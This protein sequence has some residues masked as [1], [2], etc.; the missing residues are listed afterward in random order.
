MGWALRSSADQANSVLVDV[1]AMVNSLATAATRG[2]LVSMSS[3]SLHLFDESMNVVSGSFLRRRPVTPA[4]IPTPPVTTTSVRRMADDVTMA[5]GSRIAA[6]ARGGSEA[7]VSAGD[8]SAMAID[9]SHLTLPSSVSRVGPLAPI[10]AAATASMLSLPMFNDKHVT[11][12]PEC[13]SDSSI[14][15]RF[16]LANDCFNRAVRD[17]DALAASA[18]GALPAVRNALERYSRRNLFV[19]VVI[20]SVF[21]IAAECVRVI[22][23]FENANG[24]SIVGRETGGSGVRDRISVVFFCFLFFILFGP[25]G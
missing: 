4:P 16:E 6:S 21:R 19:L 8:V 20:Q 1:A 5:A 17:R 11:L 18:I 12:I 10:S 7:I 24:V 9:S 23:P 13:L 22:R 3:T 15:A 25:D 2:E 14:A